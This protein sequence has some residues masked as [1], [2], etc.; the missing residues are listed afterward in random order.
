MT[1]N[2]PDP[3]QTRR[4]VARAWP[5]MRAATRALHLY[6]K[7][8]MRLAP[9]R[10]RTRLLRGT[11]ASLAMLE[12]ALRCLLILMGR[13]A[14]PTERA[15]WA[16]GLAR[17]ARSTRPAPPARFPWPLATHLRARSVRAPYPRHPPSEIR[18]R[19]PCAWPKA[20][21][22]RLRPVPA[23]RPDARTFRIVSDLCAVLPTVT[24]YPAP[25]FRAGESALFRLRRRHDD[26]FLFQRA[27]HIA[28]HPGFRV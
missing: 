4:R 14:P 10:V 21:G 9:G 22:G 5:L 19:T 17:T 18:N 13:K 7:A 25:G 8:V 20:R 24:A 26:A 11:S 28:R 6:V 16:V 15:P 2:V 1:R 3:S 23:I 27:Q 12:H